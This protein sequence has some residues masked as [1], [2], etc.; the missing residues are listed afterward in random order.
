ML[1]GRGALR[2]FGTMEPA[3]RHACQRCGASCT[4]HRVLL[5]EGEAERLSLLAAELEID[6]PVEG[7]TLRQVEGRC[8]FLTDDALCAVHA[9]AGLAAKPLACQQ[10]PLVVVRTEEDLRLGL[11][12]GCLTGWQTWRTA[13]EVSPERALASRVLL[14][15][16]D[17]AIETRV[18]RLCDEASSVGELL[19]RLVD[20]APVAGLPPVWSARWAEGCLRVGLPAPARLPRWALEAEAEAFAIESVR[21]MVALRLA[22]ERGGPAQ[23]AVRMLGGALLAAWRDPALAPFGTGLAQWSRALRLPGFW[24]RLTRVLS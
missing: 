22:S 2:S 9:K 11:D 24:E 14:S 23:V 1:G 16:T 7:A 3:L 15:P 6:A 10:Y 5:Q 12:P 17:Q 18:L 19:G 21:R 20:E 8:V 4:G 13:P